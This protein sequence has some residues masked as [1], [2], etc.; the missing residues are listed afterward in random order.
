MMRCH[1]RYKCIIT[2][3]DSRQSLTYDDP[4]GMVEETQDGFKVCFRG[5]DEMVITHSEDKVTLAHG[6]SV[7]SMRKDHVTANEYQT[8]MGAIPLK[9]RVVSLSSSAQQLALVYE[10]MQG[11]DVVSKAHLLLRCEEVVS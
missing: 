8:A 6:A 9:A 1:V 7:L 3:G 2:A 4:D 10:L 11:A 5:E